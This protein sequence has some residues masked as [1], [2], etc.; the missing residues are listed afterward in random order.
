MQG[1][2]QVNDASDRV[3]DGKAD[4]IE[5][6]PYRDEDEAEVLELLNV[7]LGGGPAGSRPPDFFRWKHLANPFGRSYMAV[8]ETGGRIIGLRAFMRWEFSTVRG[9]L[10]GVRA[11]DTATHP[12]HQGHGVFSTL[13]RRSLADLVGEADFIFNTPNEKS[14]PGYLKMGWR[15]V[16]RIPIYVR[17]RRPFRFVNH[18]RSWSRVGAHGSMV[19]EPGGIPASEVLA[20]PGV[21]T[22]LRNR[23]RWPGIETVRDIGYL[24]WRYGMAPLLNYRATVATVGDRVL[25]LAIFRTRPRGDLTECT[26][27]EVITGLGDRKTPRRL[28]AQVAHHSGA[29]HLTCSFPRTSSLASAA[30]RA[31]FLR[32]PVGLTLVAN[33]LGHETDPDPLDLSSW[34][35]SVGDVE[36]F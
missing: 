33:P 27:A 24:R 25:G 7:A 21:E 32:A 35:L 10:R 1:G 16:G 29:D 20:L 13:T 22:L 14:L 23:E 2:D 30:R 8:A 31:A 12:D 15:V 3:A 36:V 4:L 5:V 26:V 18:V 34:S 19:G 17:I 9:R 28:L 11:V 6:R